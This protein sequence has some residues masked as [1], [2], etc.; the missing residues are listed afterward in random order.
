[1]AKESVTLVPSSAKVSARLARHPRRDT[2]PELAVRRI[3]HAKGRRY[4]VDCRPES[5]LKRKADLVFR[6]PKVVVFID[7]CYWHGCP[8]HCKLSGPNL[9]WWRKKIDGNRQRDTE[10]DAL[11]TLAGWTVIRAWAHEDPLF[12]TRRVE[13]AL[14]ASRPAKPTSTTSSGQCQT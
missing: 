6:G 4:R 9:E 11:L 5:A 12:V 3:L 8:D 10:T 7:G 13:N 1:M 2:L 14:D